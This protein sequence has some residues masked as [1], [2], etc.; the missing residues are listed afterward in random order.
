M[1]ITIYCGSHS[2]K[3]TA[4]KENARELGRWIAKSGNAL[5]YGG[6]SVG[7]M[8][9]ISRTVLE[10][11]G[12]VIGVEPRFFI[13]AG[14]AQHDLSELIVVDTMQE[15]KARMIGLGDVFI[16]LPGGVGTLEE[17]SEIMCRI[18]IG[19]TAAPCFFLN[20]NGFWNPMIALLDTM[21]REGFMPDFDRSD[22]LFPESVGELIGML[23]ALPSDRECES[24]ESNWHC[25]PWMEKGPTQ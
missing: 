17:I 11:G 21:A 5:V 15:R 3:E 20:L 6:S 25:P 14:V 13:D 22:Y 10:N 12:R 23:E 16:A 19:I 2:S 24:S 1:N 7:L 4:F 9:I 18:R 8:G